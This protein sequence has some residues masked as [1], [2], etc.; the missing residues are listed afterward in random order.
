[1]NE[2]QQHEAEAGKIVS[3]K[4]DVLEELIDVEDWVKAKKGPKKAKSYRIRIDK[5]KFVVTVHEMNGRD[6][7][8]LDGKTPEKYLLSQKFRGGRVEPIQPDQVVEF[9]LGEVE[10]F[11]T[12]AKDPTEGNDNAQPVPVVGGR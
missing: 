4:E 12:L 1:M 8:G 11:Q 6:I 10:R 2:Q 7:L 3:P 5:D 9:H